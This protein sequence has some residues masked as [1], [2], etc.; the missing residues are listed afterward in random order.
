MDASVAF[1]NHPLAWRRR[2]RGDDMG[3]GRGGWGASKEWV[4]IWGMT[5]K[6]MLSEHQEYERVV[7][8][9]QK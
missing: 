8:E 9:Y 4:K 6:E 1:G 7:L 3:R 5:R 2:R